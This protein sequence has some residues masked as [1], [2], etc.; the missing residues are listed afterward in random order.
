M[1]GYGSGRWYRHDKQTTTDNVNSI[2]I[3]LLRKSGCLPISFYW[4]D[5][6][7]GTLSWSRGDQSAGTVS[8][9]VT[10]DQLIVQGV[11]PWQEI[12]E[13]V[14]FDRT[15]CNF[16]GQR[17]WFLCPNCGRRIGVIYLVGARFLCRYCHKLPYT[18]Q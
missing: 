3:R 4:S 5:V 14:W 1:G 18:S 2:D 17:L 10:Q 16:G 9:E 12:H 8:F 6:W 15:E 7:L 13:T 11:E